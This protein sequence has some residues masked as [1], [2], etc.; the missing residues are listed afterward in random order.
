LS[1]AG[2][3]RERERAFILFVFEDARA[4]AYRSGISGAILDA[5]TRLIL[6]LLLLLLLLATAA[7]P[8]APA[9]QHMLRMCRSAAFRRQQH[10]VNIPAGAGAAAPDR[11]LSAR[12]WN[13]KL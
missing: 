2:Q 13:L 1:E 12:A 6:L 4:A 10:L 5:A 9:V 11:D 8:A 3:E 7:A